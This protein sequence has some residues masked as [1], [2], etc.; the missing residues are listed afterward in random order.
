MGT[1][2][3]GDIIELVTIKFYKNGNKHLK[4]N[5]D[6]MLRFNV[7]VSRLLGWVRSKEEFTT[8]SDYTKPVNDNVWETSNSMKVTASNIFKL[9]NKAA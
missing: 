7:T 4:F 2:P 3:C 8:E 1:A 6:A 9:T 5:Q